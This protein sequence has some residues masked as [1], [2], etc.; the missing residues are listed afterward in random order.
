MTEQ[1]Y[2]S[3]PNEQP[4]LEDNRK[5]KS[6]R[7]ILQKDIKLNIPVL[8]LR[9]KIFAFTL[10]VKGL[11]WQERRVGRKKTKRKEK[12]YFSSP[13]ASDHPKLKI[14]QKNSTHNQHLCQQNPSFTSIIFI[15]IFNLWKL[16][17]RQWL[18]KLNTWCVL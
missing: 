13:E 5:K 10:P 6:G 12:L 14:K 3:K 15:F 18:L 1:N 2:N 8:T 7:Y 17:I 11:V 16:C 9:S 4:N